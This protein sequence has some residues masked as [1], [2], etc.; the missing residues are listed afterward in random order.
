MSQPRRCPLEKL[1]GLFPPSWRLCPAQ[2]RFQRPP[3]S[4]PLALHRHLCKARRSWNLS[5]RY[6]PQRLVLSSGFPNR[7]PQPWLLYRSGRFPGQP[8]LPLPLLLGARALEHRSQSQRCWN[9]SLQ[10][11]GL[12]SRR[13]SC[14]PME[15]YSRTLL[16]MGTSLFP[17][18]W[19][20]LL[21]D[22]CHNQPQPQ[23]LSRL[24]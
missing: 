9:R 5:R 20:L 24:Q 17:G 16:C 22:P 1:F 19:A 11:R 23:H 21:S 15:P 13:R 7:R 4:L 14:S 6:W 10:W 2:L 18:P 3:L 12:S 8:W